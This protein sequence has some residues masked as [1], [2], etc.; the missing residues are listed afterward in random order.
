MKKMKVVLLVFVMLLVFASTAFADQQTGTYIHQG[1]KL[2]AHYAAYDSHIG[3]YMSI[4][5][6]RVTTSGEV[7]IDSFSEEGGRPGHDIHQGARDLGNQPAGTY[8]YVAVAPSGWMGPSVW[9]SS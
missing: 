3:G 6:Y 5:I 4:Y 9:F 2:T 8:K 1:G 7:L